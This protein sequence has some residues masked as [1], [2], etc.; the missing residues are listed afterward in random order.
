MA[1]KIIAKTKE[2]LPQWLFQTGPVWVY[3]Y[4]LE[5]CKPWFFIKIGKRKVLRDRESPIETVQPH[6]GLCSSRGIF[7]TMGRLILLP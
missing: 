7:Y 5:L 1:T 4:K 3:S 6:M 2:I